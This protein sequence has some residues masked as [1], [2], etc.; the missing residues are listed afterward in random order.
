MIK[1]ESRFQRI[2]HA[3]SLNAMENLN[4]TYKQPSL[5]SNSTDK[6]IKVQVNGSIETQ[7]DK[8][9]H[10]QKLKK[11]FLSSVAMLSGSV[12]TSLS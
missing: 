1:L 3:L 11:M 10:V 12:S 6:W 7:H 9:G 8:I 5:L 2:G 4:F